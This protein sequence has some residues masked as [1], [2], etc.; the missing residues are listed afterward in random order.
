MAKTQN[1]IYFY[2]HK[3]FVSNFSVTIL[4]PFFQVRGQNSQTRM[5][6]KQIFLSNYRHI[7]PTPHHQSGLSE[8]QW[9]VNLPFQ[10]GEHLLITML[11]G[12]SSREGSLWFSMM[13][14]SRWMQYI[15][16]DKLLM[17]EGIRENFMERVTSG[18]D[19]DENRRCLLLQAQR[20]VPV[21]VIW[22]DTWPRDCT[23]QE[24]PKVKFPEVTSEG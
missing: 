2:L 6:N 4:E 19:L 22:P 13:W 9:L 10:L 11:S 16:D 24:L 21:K 3:A 14:S 8:F 23:S 7:F 20:I 5:W 17:G 1:W 18:L 12:H 15:G